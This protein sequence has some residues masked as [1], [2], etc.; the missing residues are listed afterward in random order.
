VYQ[1]KWA[2]LNGEPINIFVN[3]ADER[4]IE[5]IGTDSHLLKDL[6]TV[7]VGMKPYQVGKGIPKQT[8][9][10]VKKRV[11]DS[12]YRKD[13]SYRPLLRGR[14]IDK[15]NVKWKGD[16]WIKYGDHLAEP[17]PSAHFDAPIKI[18]VR[19]TGDSLIAALDTDRFVCMNNMHVIMPRDESC[20][21]LFILGSL[22]SRL[23]NYYFQWLNPEKGEALAEVKKEHVE[24]LP[25]KRTDTKQME[26]IIRIVGQILQAKKRDRG[27]E[28]TGLEREIDRLVYH[29]YGLTN[30]E[31]K[32]VEESR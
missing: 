13:K 5:K 30:D 17:R 6:C 28:T 10:V 8:P 23:L 20:N 11:F 15:Y 18:V 14:D 4:I 2:T 7:T 16:R 21:L 31:I 19:Q 27:A 32:I 26:S 1:H 24:K 22:N 12:T 29:L 9:E 3:P 25:M